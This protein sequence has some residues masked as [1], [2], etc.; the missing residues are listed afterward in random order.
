MSFWSRIKAWFRQERSTPPHSRAPAPAQ[1][2]ATDLEDPAFAD[3]ADA[4]LNAEPEPTYEP[5]TARRQDLEAAESDP[6]PAALEK[7]ASALPKGRGIARFERDEELTV[8]LEGP[9]EEIMWA[10]SRRI[11][12]GRMDLPTLPSTS[13]AVIDLANNPTVEF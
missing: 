10:I 11:E 7:V 12:S 9:E 8:I 2:S 1:D 3:A 4:G 13:M 5:G 6:N